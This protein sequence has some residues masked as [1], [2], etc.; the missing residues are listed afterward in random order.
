MIF[1]WFDNYV[2][3]IFVTQC[4]D[5]VVFFVIFVLF[6]VILPT[7]MDCELEEFVFI[8][9]NFPYQEKSLDVDKEN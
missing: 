7:I 6:Y 9:Y 4:C 1:L 8:C 5:F 3:C 2:D